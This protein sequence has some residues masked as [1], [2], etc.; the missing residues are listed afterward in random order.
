MLN[1]KLSQSFFKEGQLFRGRGAEPVGKFRT[2]ACLDT[3]H[4]KGELSDTV[5]DESSGRKG[6]VFPKCLQI[7]ETAVFFQEGVLVVS[8]FSGS[9]TNQTTL[10]NI[11]DV[12]LYSLSGIT[13]LL[14]GFGDILGIWQFHRHLAA[15]SRKTVHSKSTKDFP[16]AFG[17]SRL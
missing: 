7:P 1:S 15:L 3:L 6:T 8:T 5:P 9:D 16:C 11:F 10:W 14:I 2:V 12:D 4:D 17:V 13:H